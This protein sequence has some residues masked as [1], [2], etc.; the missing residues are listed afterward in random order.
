MDKKDRRL[1]LS[2]YFKQKK[3][4]VMRIRIY[5]LIFA[6][7]SLGFL[8]CNQDDSPVIETIDGEKITVKRFERDYEIALDTFSRQYNIEKKTL[9]DDILSKDIKDLPQQLQ[10]IH[11]QFDKKNFYENSYRDF[12]IIAKAAEKSGFTNR[13]DIKNILEFMRIQTLSQLFILEELEKKIKISED[14]VKAECEKLRK[15]SPEAAS[16]PLSDCLKFAR[17]E[18]KLQYFKQNQDK[19][20]DRIKEGVSIKHNDAFDLDEYLKNTKGSKPTEENPPAK[21]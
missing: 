12:L 8:G 13:T 9:I 14:D 15:S 20:K 3:G 6:A 7:I 21:N 19:V 11:Y 17:G 18:L 4:S 2:F 1:S 16:K 5:T 10:Q